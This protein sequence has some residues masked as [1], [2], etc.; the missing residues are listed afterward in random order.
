MSQR[1]LMLSP[2]VQF[3]ETRK[4]L[5]SSPVNKLPLLLRFLFNA[6]T[7]GEQVFLIQPQSLSFIDHWPL[8][9]HVRFSIRIPSKYLGPVPSG[10]RSEQTDPGLLSPTQA[11]R[12]EEKFICE[13]IGHLISRSKNNKQKV[14]N[15]KKS[16]GD[17]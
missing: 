4:S 2:S 12:G 1:E 14:N 15:K 11:D 16:L 5:N 10:Q 8:D 7:R 17:N 6:S 9:W 3:V 13:S